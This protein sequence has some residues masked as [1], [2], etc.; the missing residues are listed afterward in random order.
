MREAALALRDRVVALR[1]PLATL[2]ALE[3][4]VDTE[5]I[6]RQF[7][8]HVLPRLAN[9]DAP[10]LVVVGGSTGSGKSL[11][12]NSVLGADISRSGVLR[13]TSRCPVLV[14]HPDAAAWFTTGGILPGLARVTGATS[15]TGENGS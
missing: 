12:V 13:P 11:L 5:A 2:G 1:F 14:H 8:D 10:A 6:V 9:L 4:R 3:A 15:E 7:D